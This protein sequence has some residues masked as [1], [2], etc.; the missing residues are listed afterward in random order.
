MTVNPASVSLPVFQNYLQS[1]IAPRP[2]AFASTTD[3]D[4]NVN[5]SPFSFFNVFGV[6]P[7]T[8]VFSPSRRVRDGSTKHSLE[9]LL[10]TDEVVINIVDYAMVEQMSL[11]SCEYPKGVN[12][13][14]KAG[15]TEAASTL[16][17]PPRVAESK[18]A[19]ECKV[20]Q[21]LQ[22]GQEGGAPNL[23]ICEVLLAHFDPSILNENGLIDPTR[24]DWVARMGGDWY[25][26]ASGSALFEVP[27]PSVHLGVGVDAIPAHIRSH[28]LLTANELGRLGNLTALPEPSE[29]EAFWQEHDGTEP[30]VLTKKLL[31]EGRV[32]EAWMALTR[33]APRTKTPGIVVRPAS[34]TDVP[35]IV[36]LYRRAAR[37]GWGIARA[38]DEVTEAYVRH[39]LTQGTQRGYCLVAEHPAEEG[40]VVGEVH[41]YRLAPRLFDHML[42][43]LTV[44][45]DPDFQGQGVGSLLFER[46]LRT[47]ETERPDIRRIELNVRESNARAI[48]LYEKM[49]FRREGR[50]E[51]RVPTRNGGLEADIPMGWLNPNYADV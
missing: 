30:V 10:E 41:C 23:I 14:V 27:K 5:L 35:A 37:Q 26:R 12:E 16:V 20:R 15:F 43:D 19:F 47:V 51:N 8:L 9:N 22:L 33:I 48:A 44:A 6:N 32:R 36:D 50:L 11:A 13:F 1:A 38:E 34:L 39:N 7:P 4:G 21:I 42:S 17:R 3:R 18:A 29:T 31:A 40:R 2:I 24:T 46:L 28:I 25:C 49:G 45:V